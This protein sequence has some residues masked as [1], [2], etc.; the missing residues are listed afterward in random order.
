MRGARPTTDDG[1][2]TPAAGNLRRANGPPTGAGQR[3]CDTDV[4]GGTTLNLT[5]ANFS[6][7]AQVFVD[8]VAAD[9]LFVGGGTILA[10][11]PAGAPGVVTVRVENA[12]AVT[13]ILA[14]ATNYLTWQNIRADP[15][16]RCADYLRRR[17]LTGADAKL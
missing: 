15:D 3:G 5:G 17:G 9:V 10:V 12:D 4:A 2:K 1:R 7:G 8:D 6:A 16:A 13:I 11:T 14:G